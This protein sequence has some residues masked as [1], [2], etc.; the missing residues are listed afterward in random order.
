M[1]FL[2]NSPP[3][4]H[5]NNLNWVV[6]LG[7]GVIQ[8]KGTHLDHTIFGQKV[9]ARKYAVDLANEVVFL[10]LMACWLQNFRPHSAKTILGHKKLKWV[11]FDY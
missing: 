9:A 7:G 2:H 3:Q 10:C 11:F 6:L 8:S 1:I 5:P 4:N